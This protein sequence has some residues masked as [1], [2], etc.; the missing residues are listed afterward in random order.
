MATAFKPRERSSRFIARNP[1]KL[2]GARV[3]TCG[4]AR[5]TRPSS[6]GN[7]FAPIRSGETVKNRLR[8]HPLC[9]G[10]SDA[11]CRHEALSTSSG[12]RRREL[13]GEAAVFDEKRV[14]GVDGG[15]ERWVVVFK[16]A[17]R[18]A[19]FAG[20]LLKFSRIVG[21]RNYFS[22]LPL[23]GITCLDLFERVS[24]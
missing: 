13:H 12:W 1:E 24:Q 9:V 10:D 21:F 17:V 23:C 11:S 6:R 4:K 7:V 3:G 14:E 2:G 18:E 15:V 5:R 16:L 19:V 8:N 20:K 22:V